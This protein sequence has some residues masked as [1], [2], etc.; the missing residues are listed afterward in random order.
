MATVRTAPYA[1]MN[2]LVDLGTGN[3]NAPAA[4]FSEVVMPAGHAD[5]VDYRTGNEKSVE[6]RKAIVGIRYTN[7]ILRRGYIGSLDLFQWWK[8]V[9]SGQ[10]GT[11]RNVVISVLDEERAG[12]VLTVRL[13]NAVPVGYRLSDLHAEGGTLLMEEIELAYESFDVE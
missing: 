11:R 4:G 13:R 7:V 10:A 9:R 3:P 2:F 6:P 1:G 8:A 5:V 12:P